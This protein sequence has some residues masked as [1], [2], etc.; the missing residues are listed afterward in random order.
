MSIAVLDFFF[1]NPPHGRWKDWTAM[2]ETLQER[3]TRRIYELWERRRLSQAQLV[4]ATGK[5][6]STIHRIIHGHQPVTLDLLDAV[7]DLVQIP[8]AELL[9][10]EGTQ[11]RVLPPDE[12]EMLSYF[13][14]WPKATREAL[15][16][17]SRFFAASPPL[18][19]QLRAALEYLRG[20]GKGERDRAVAYL[21]LLH[22]GGLSRDVRIALGLPEA[23]DAPRT[24]RRKGTTA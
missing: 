19:A 6:A 7:A 23:D 17:F 5:H 8:A 18:D 16:I 24:P 13:R 11:V 12:A 2:K 21:L 4:E 1:W 22:E 3:A 9:A 10:D 14:T 15:L 20:M